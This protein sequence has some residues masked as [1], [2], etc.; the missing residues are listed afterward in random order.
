[1]EL[2]IILEEELVTY[3][4][5]MLKQVQEAMEPCSQQ[6]AS[7]V[8]VAPSA[9]HAQLDNSYMIIHSEN[10]FLASTSLKAHMTIKRQK[11]HQSAHTTA[12]SLVQSKKIQNA[13][14][15]LMKNSKKLVAMN[16][17]SS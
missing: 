3:K 11:L 5:D 8:T 9:H 14:T 7:Q 2:S 12:K 4:R 13:L 17:S 15:W 1:M 16:S 6:N 10:V